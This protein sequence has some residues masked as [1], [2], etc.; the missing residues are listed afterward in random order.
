MFTIAGPCHEGHAVDTE[1]LGHYVTIVCSSPDV[2]VAVAEMLGSGIVT[3]PR[4]ALVGRVPWETSKNEHKPTTT[5]TTA[6]D[7]I[8]RSHS[9]RADGNEEPSRGRGFDRTKRPG[10]F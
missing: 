5:S 3:A 6:V 1:I 7:P 10:L 9:P 8:P 2:A 4:K